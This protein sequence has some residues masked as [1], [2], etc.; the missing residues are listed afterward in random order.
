MFAAQRIKAIAVR[1]VVV[2]ELV[3]RQTAVMAAGARAPRLALALALALALRPAPLRALDICEYSPFTLFAARA[4]TNLL[5]EV[6]FLKE[7]RNP[8]RVALFPAVGPPNY[9]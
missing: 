1:R 6:P 2:A 7:E 5:F 3:R 9:Q 8:Q 4:I